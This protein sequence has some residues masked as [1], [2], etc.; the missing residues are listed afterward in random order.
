MKGRAVKTRLCLM[1]WILAAA[2]LT[3]AL[4]QSKFACSQI[5]SASALPT[6][7]GK[8]A[9]FYRTSA[10]LKMQHPM[11]EAVV[12][13]L[14]KLSAA[15][16][17][18]GTILVY[19]SIPSKSQGMPGNLPD[20]AS[21]YGYDPAI[22][23]A[24]YDDI[25]ARLDQAGIVAPDLMRA[26]QAGGSDERPFLGS[27]FHWTSSGA[28]LAAKAIGSAIRAQPAYADL[29][30]LNFASVPTAPVDSFSTMRR[31]L[32]GYCINPLPPVEMMG[33]KTTKVEAAGAADVG[34]DIF[35]ASDQA[36]QIVL[37]GTSFS[38]SEV[39]NFAGF[40]SEFSGLEVINQA[41]TGG[42]QFGAI[43][44]YLTSSEFKDQ[45]PRFLVWE[46][47][48][49]NNLGQ[50][51]LTQL[52][53]L[54]A[55]AGNTCTEHLATTV[56]DGTTLVADLGTAKAT[57]VDAIFA[58]FGA[59]G[60]RR[61]H[62]RLEGKDGLVRSAFIERAERLQATGRF[63]LGMS[64]FHMPDLSR[65]SVEFDRPVTGNPSLSLCLTRKG[66]AS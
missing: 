49:Y 31:I 33:W 12:Q 15:L 40:L 20:D 58:D 63:Y 3:P 50:Y 23:A 45:R 61:A 27:D 35:A 30:P 4:A 65:I 54:I 11:D 64:A 29:T 44:S 52:E 25:I 2:P 60:P 18:N 17:K 42:N 14:A 62:F 16:A 59:E 55:A 38:D 21:D 36:A 56:V 19:A 46:N 1:I 5:E 48:I 57:N 10:D 28:R 43:T 26:L 53:E 51:G 6:V 34:L 32:Q 9:V 39:N 47:P 24:V 37:V 41:I 22:D 13:H 66:D 8:D 7:E